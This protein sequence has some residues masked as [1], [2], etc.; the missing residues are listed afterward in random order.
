M[1]LQRYQWL[2]LS[3]TALPRVFFETI[4]GTVRME[5]RKGYL[6][7]YKSSYVNIVGNLCFGTAFYT[8]EPREN[9]LKRIPEALDTHTWIDIAET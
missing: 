5:S 7:L 8:K 3:A 9:K 4:N 1:I 2:Q 6:D